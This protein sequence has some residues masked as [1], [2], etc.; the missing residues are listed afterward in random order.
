MSPNLQ[1]L[2]LHGAL[3]WAKAADRMTGGS[4]CGMADKAHVS[5][6]SGAPA[7]DPSINLMSGMLLH[8]MNTQP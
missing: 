8:L 5:F 6:L 7:P 3:P 4:P 2:V 1:R